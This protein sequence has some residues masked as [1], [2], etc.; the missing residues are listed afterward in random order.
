MVKKNFFLGLKSLCISLICLGE[1]FTFSAG[2]IEFPRAPERDPP[3]STAAGGR[4]GGCVSGKYPIKAFTPGDDNY[5]TTVSSRPELFIYLP[6][7]QAKF[8]QFSL[9]QENGENIDTQEIPI[10]QGDYVIKINLPENISLETGSKYQWEA[11][12]ICNPMLINTGN[13][14]NGIIEKVTLPPEV[15][16]QLNNQNPL[17]QAQL[18][19]NQNIWSETLSLV[20][21]LRESQPEQWQQLLTSVGL[22]DYADKEFQSTL[23]DNTI[24]KDEGEN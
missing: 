19:A 21:N 6:K 9:K 13:Y 10:D 7:T 15:Q 4:R 3:K 22:Q 24:E 14:T 16:T 8:L 2:A 18:Y 5:I 17:E 1:V 11:S 23:K 20:S 12:L